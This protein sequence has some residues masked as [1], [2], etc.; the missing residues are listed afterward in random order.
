MRFIFLLFLVTGCAGFAIRDGIYNQDEAFNEYTNLYVLYKLK[1]RQTEYLNYP[2]FVQFTDTGFP[3]VGKCY[4]TSNNNASRTIT[5]NRKYWENTTE[6][7]RIKLIFHEFGHCDLDFDHQQEV[8]GIMNSH[9]RYF[10]LTEDVIRDFFWE[11][12]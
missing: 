6:D 12:K 8:D 1:Y 10:E 4:R 7:D 3:S 11:G 5:I 9:I 2:I